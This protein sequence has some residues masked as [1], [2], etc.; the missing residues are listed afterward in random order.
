MHGDG[1]HLTSFTNIARI[2]LGRFRAFQRLGYELRR[3]R[4]LHI[5]Y[6]RNDTDEQKRCI[7]DDVQDKRYRYRIFWQKKS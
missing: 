2:Q 5:T 1:D 3:P 4:R 7:A 6:T